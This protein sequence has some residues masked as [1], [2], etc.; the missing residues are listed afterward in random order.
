[1]AFGA[2]SDSDAVRCWSADPGAVTVEQAQSALLKQPMQSQWK[3]TRC[4]MPARPPLKA[5]PI[6]ILLTDLG[7]LHW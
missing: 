7:G 1:M 2:S 4:M 6:C 5:E 3:I